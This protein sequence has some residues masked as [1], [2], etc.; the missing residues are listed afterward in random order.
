MTT[1]GLPQE[2]PD[3]SLVLGGPLFQIWRRAQLSG[4]A[5]ELVRRRVVVIILLTWLPLATLSA[6]EGHLFGNQT[7]TFLHDIELHVRL[8]VALPVLI[9]AELEVH[10]RFGP[11]LRQFVERRVVSAEETPNFYA[12]IATAKRAGNSLWLELALLFFVYTAGHWIWRGN[13]ALGVATWYGV[14]EKGALHLTHAGYWYVFASIPI[15]QFI[16]LRWYLRLVI[17]FWLLW[18]VS[19]LKLHLLATHPDRAGGIGFLGRSSYAFGPFLFA[20]GASLAGM[21]ASRVFYQGQNLLSFKVTIA[22][23]V[24]FL[25]LLIVV[26]LMMFTPVLV[27][28]KRRGLSAYG[29]LATVYV[30]A[31]DKKWIRGG[32]KDEPILGAADIQS[33]ADL[34]NSYEVV[35]EMQLVPFGLADLGQLVG[36]V[37]LP[38]MPLVLTI[39]PLDEL[40]ARII[41]IIF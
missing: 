29:A 30:E 8:L 10:R 38:I 13:V 22:T 2:P 9:F 20:Q 35:Q 23:V 24:G 21:I 5:L 34:G 40:L 16:L 7:L 27:E 36:A 18:R 31:F 25:S 32:A 3:F 6:V 33:L 28:T 19:Q 37:A 14:P 12:A 15:F 1:P 39:V 4:P 11:V 17:W 41:K 26:P